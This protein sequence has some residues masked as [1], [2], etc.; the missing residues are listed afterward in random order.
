MDADDC[1]ILCLLIREEIVSFLKVFRF[2][3][4]NSRRSNDHHTVALYI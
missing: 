3:E 1:D 4:G 2:P